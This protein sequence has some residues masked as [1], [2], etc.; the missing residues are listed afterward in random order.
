[1]AKEIATTTKTTGTVAVVNQKALDRL[2][3][4]SPSDSRD[5]MLPKIL[6]AQG[7]SKSVAEGKAVMGEFRG[8]LDNKLLGNKEKGFEAIP[9]YIS[10]SWIVFTEEKGTLKYTGQ[11]PFGPE[12]A[13][14]TW[15]DVDAQGRKVR[16]DQSLNMYCILPS[17]VTEGIFMPYLISFRR[18]SYT[19]GKKLITLKEK[20][21]MFKRPLASTTITVTCRQ[22]K[23]DKGVFYVYD[24]A[25]CR[26]TTGEEIEAVGPWFDLVKLQAVKVDDSDLETETNVTAH[27]VHTHDDIDFSDKF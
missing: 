8:S 23:N 18:T 12:N 21:K 5:I 22:D 16:R 11:V 4:D 14:W 26:P 20:L 19:A 24:I 9:F 10:K 25:Q 15:D 13:N 17:E 6:L 2:M 27:A 7:L 3:D 1:M